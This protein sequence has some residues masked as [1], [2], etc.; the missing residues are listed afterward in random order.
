MLHMQEKPITLPWHLQYSSGGGG[1]DL[2]V[3]PRYITVILYCTSYTP[4]S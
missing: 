3:H 4:Y 1:G 2:Y